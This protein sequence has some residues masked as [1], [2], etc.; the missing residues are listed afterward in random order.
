M[1]QKQ[2]HNKIIN[3]KKFYRMSIFIKKGIN[4]MRMCGIIK[5]RFIWTDRDK[6]TAK[7]NT[8]KTKI[9]LLTTSNTTEEKK[10]ENNAF[11][12]LHC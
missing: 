11:Y 12:M 6:K 2:K 9:I 1:I 4:G 3:T 8:K 10:R 5:Y 7:K